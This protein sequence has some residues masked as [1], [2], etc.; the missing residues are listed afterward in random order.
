[1]A[2]ASCDKFLDETPDN[3]AELD[4]DDKIANI[5]VSAYPSTH[6]GE[7]AELA[8]DN[9][10]EVVGPGY[11]TYNKLQDELA[12]W[13]DATE[14]EQD[15]PFELWDKSYK[16]IAACNAA[17]DAIAQ[18]GNPKELDP[19]R[20]EALVARAYNHFVLVNIFSKA[21]S[22]LTS[23]TDLGIPYMLTSETT[24]AP[25]YERGTVAGVY[26]NIEKDLLEGLPLINDAAYSV[27]AYHFNRKAAYAFAARFYLYYVL[28]DKSNYDKVIEYAHEVLG[29]NAPSALRDWKTVG[30]LTPNNSVRSKAFI[31]AG[32]RANLLLQSTYS[33]WPVIHGPFGVGDKYCHGKKIADT[34]TSN[35]PG[36]WDGTFHFWVPQ[37]SG[38][39]KVIMAKMPY[40]FEFTDPVKQIGFSHTVVAAFTSDDVL[41]NRAEAY[42]MKG[43][44]DAAAQ[45]LTYWASAFTTSATQI[46][47][48]RINSVYG[49][50]MAYYTPTEPT[51]KK[52]LNPD[53]TVEKGTQENF[54]HAI[55]HARR[56]M[57]LH[58]GLRW[59]D[60]KR[61]GIEI[62]RRTL[63]NGKITV[64]DTMTKDDPRR[65][66][67]LP[68]SV[69]TAGLEGNP[70]N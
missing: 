59:F 27:V 43:D 70:R 4:S 30:S 19:Q 45:D 33:S 36:F 50:A 69:I 52:A 53:F 49:D 48:E 28:G 22:P 67:Q 9:T 6:F 34:E 41:L 11:V 37:Y 13:T 21:Y 5:L 39:A 23:D 3:R 46:T 12:T 63:N 60:V 47:I 55:L 16:A 58:E 29:D 65:A 62:C 15:S 56:V 42:A 31:D 57:M 64:N 18:R 14:K 32:D 26:S 54:I 10:D 51:P 44:F 35:A 2:L 17:L 38:L 68:Q 40:L 7:I 25:K 8:S 66:I 1:M 61:Y 24:V 20:G